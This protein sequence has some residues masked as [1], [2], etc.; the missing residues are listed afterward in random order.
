MRDYL[1]LLNIELDIGS[2]DRLTYFKSVHR[3][4]VKRS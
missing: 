1:Q 3:T 2:S 4:K